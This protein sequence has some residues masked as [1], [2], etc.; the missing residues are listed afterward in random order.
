MAIYP[1]RGSLEWDVP[2]KQYIQDTLA[3]EVANHTP[4][5]EL[6]YA[7]TTTPITTTNVQPNLYVIA[8]LSLTVVGAGR[9]VDI[10]G[11]LPRVYHSVAGTG[12]NV[13]MMWKKDDGAYAY[14]QIV[15]THSPETTSGP[16]VSV[17]RRMVLDDGG[18]YSF[19]FGVAGDAAG[20]T[21]VT[22]GGLNPA[23]SS[24]V[25]R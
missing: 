6:A 14:G 3:E 21:S 8:P 12:V 16:P 11:Y 17:R 7:Q 5:S 15:V 25:S 9:A 4:G 19:I 22:P 10:E 2:L 18:V 1:A 13:G 23:F 20:T 24:V